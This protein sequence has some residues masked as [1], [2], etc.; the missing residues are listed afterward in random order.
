MV[1]TF[2]FPTH[3]AFQ[4]PPPVNYCTGTVRFFSPAAAGSVGAAPRFLKDTISFPHSVSVPKR[5]GYRR[6]GAAVASG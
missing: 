4:V 1:F 3:Q 6:P 5:Q 2:L